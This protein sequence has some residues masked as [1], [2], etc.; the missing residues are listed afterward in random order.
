MGE[1]ETDTGNVE[2]VEEESL[3]AADIERALKDPAPDIDALLAVARVARYSRSARKTVEKTLEGMRGRGETKNVER[4]VRIGAGLWIL[5]AIRE[6]KELLLNCRANI[7]GAF[8]LAK[9]LVHL[10]SPDE[11]AEILA[12]T[13][14]R[15]PQSES[16]RTAL[17]EAWL[18]AGNP[19]E[20]KKALRELEKVAGKSAKTFTLRGR[21]LDLTGDH[22]G[23]RE[24][25]QKAIDANPRYADALFRLAYSMDLYGDDEPAIE[26]YEKCVAFPRPNVNALINLG[27]LLEDRGEYDRA[28]E[29]YETVLK[30]YPNHPRAQAFLKDALSSQVEVVDEERERM[31]DRRW[32]TLQI[33]ITDFELSVRS[34][35][36]LN[37]MNIRTLGDLVQKTEVELLSYKNFGETSLGEIKV[38]LESK[39]LRLGINLDELRRGERRQRLDELFQKGREDD[40]VSLK[41]INELGLS[42]RSRKCMEVLSIDSIGDLMG[43]SEKELLACKNFGQTSLLEVKRKLA[44]HGVSLAED[45]GDGEADLES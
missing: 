37:K 25:F 30:S 28:V 20:A 21:L 38:I 5:G 14:N 27:V 22:E 12:K 11:G 23:A 36:C 31:E 33:P 3:S 34:R 44:E 6:A 10:R 1:A 26:L 9:T 15:K 35:N 24:Q 29:C 18:E 32:Q 40:E 13:A 17:V 45:A 2:V 4:A 7:T 42:I 8:F 43:K 16:I 19:V 39:N 41:P